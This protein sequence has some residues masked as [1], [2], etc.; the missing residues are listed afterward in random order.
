[1]NQLSLPQ[2]AQVVALLTEG[3]AIRATERLTGVP[4]YGQAHWGTDRGRL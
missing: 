3:T 2:Q 4:R 1:M